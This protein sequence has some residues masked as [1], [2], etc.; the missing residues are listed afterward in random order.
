MTTKRFRVTMVEFLTKQAWSGQQ[1]HAAF[2][3]LAPMLATQN[4]AIIELDMKGVERLDASCS[5]EALANLIERFRGKKWFFLSH[6]ANQTVQ[7]N[8]DMALHKSEMSIIARRADGSYEVLGL[9]LKDHLVETLEVIEA[10]GEA[11]SRAVCAA[12][13]G[14]ALT[15]CNNRLKDLSDAGLVARL[16]GAAESGGKEFSYMAL[17]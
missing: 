4:E 7:E 16:E 8:I 14:L 5:R 10:K 17:R 2:T 12:I 3:K 11:T 1:G 15:A 13:K 6:L 9:A